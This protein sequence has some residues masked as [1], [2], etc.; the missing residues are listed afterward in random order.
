M[1]KCVYLHTRMKKYDS[2]C[3]HNELT[4]SER[5][6]ILSQKRNISSLQEYIISSMKKLWADKKTLLRVTK[7]DFT[8]GHPNDIGKYKIEFPDGRDLIHSNVLA[9]IPNF[10]WPNYPTVV[11]SESEASVFKACWI[12]YI[13]AQVRLME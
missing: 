12:E 5:I 13:D 8:H 1:Q 2:I 3:H 7:V 11:D 4:Q 9:H 6:R 10:V